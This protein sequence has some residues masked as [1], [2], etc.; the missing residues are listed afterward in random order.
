MLST[1]TKREQGLVALIVVAIGLA[2]LYYTYVFTPTADELVATREHVEA[3]AQSNRTSARELRAGNLKRLK[4]DAERYAEQL[5][6]MKRLV[7]TANEVP[8]LL[9]QVSNAARRSGLD[10]AA[11]TPQAVATS[12]ET[13]DAHKYRIAVKGS[14]LRI[15]GFFGEIGSLPRIMTASTV[16]M[17]PSTKLGEAQ[18]LARKARMAAPTEATLVTEFDLETYVVRASAPT[19]TTTRGGTT[20]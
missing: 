12:G 15:A 5:E 18:P 9:E 8:A 6:V 10:L 14:Y 4:A 1:L 19:A 3:L 11:V 7:P 2:G 17:T 13:Y 20:P 16:K